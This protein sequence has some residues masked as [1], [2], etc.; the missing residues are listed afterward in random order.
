MARLA[1]LA[2]ALQPEAP[3][4][5]QLAYWFRLEI[6]SNYG[7]DIQQS[8]LTVL[9]VLEHLHV[10]LVEVARVLGKSKCVAGHRVPGAN[11]D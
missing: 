9:P 11:V 6:S 4:P 8:Q 2:E 7:A 5:V 1:R 3:Q 10:E